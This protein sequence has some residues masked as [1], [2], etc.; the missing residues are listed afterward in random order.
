[1]WKRADWFGRTFALKCFAHFLSTDYPDVRRF[2]MTSACLPRRVFLKLR[3]F[4]VHRIPWLCVGRPN[5]VLRLVHAGIV[6]RSCGDALPKVALAAE[7]SGTA[8]RTK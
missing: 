1:M 5:F 4:G 6:Q 7:K 3:Q 8:F 2:S